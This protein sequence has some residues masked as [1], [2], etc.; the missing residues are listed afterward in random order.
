MCYRQDVVIFQQIQFNKNYM[1][2]FVLAIETS[3]VLHDLGYFIAV[4]YIHMIRTEY[5]VTYWAS[6]SSSSAYK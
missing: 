5:I 4:F 2:S 3:S 6:S 1:W